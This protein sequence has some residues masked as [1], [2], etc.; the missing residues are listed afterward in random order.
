MEPS[1]ELVERLGKLRMGHSKG[2]QWHEGDANDWYGRLH[3]PSFKT[4][5]MLAGNSA[6]G[7]VITDLPEKYRV[8]VKVV[9]SLHKEGHNRMRSTWDGYMSTSWDSCKYSWRE[10]SCISAL[11]WTTMA[12]WYTCGPYKSSRKHWRPSRYSRQ[13]LRMNLRRGCEK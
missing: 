5:I 11:L 12:G 4:V 9:H 1:R 6:N 7:M 13:R 2:S 10:G 3:H 8:A